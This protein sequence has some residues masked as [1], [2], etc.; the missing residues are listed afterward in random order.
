MINV[1][2]AKLPNLTVP[3]LFRDCSV[4]CVLYFSRRSRSIPFR[5]VP[6]FSNHRKL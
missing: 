4:P 3:W 1:I 5:S 2:E 6:D